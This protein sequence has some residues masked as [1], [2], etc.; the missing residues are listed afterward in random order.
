MTESSSSSDEEE[1]AKL[2]SAAWPC[3]SHRTILKG[4]NLDTELKPKKKSLRIL[5][6]FKD[7]GDYRNVDATAEQ[8]AFIAKKLTSWL[9][10]SISVVDGQTSQS[11]TSVAMVDDS[12]TYDFQLFS[13]SEPGPPVEAA[14]PERRKQR[15]L[16]SSSDSD[17]DGE[18]AK[19]SSAAV[20]YDQILQSSQL[21]APQDQQVTSN[22]SPTNNHSTLTSAK[23]SM[24]IPRNPPCDVE[25]KKRKRL[26]ESDGEKSEVQDRCR[27]DKKKKKKRK[28]RTTVGDGKNLETLNKS[29]LPEGNKTCQT[30]AQSFVKEQ[31]KDSMS[32]N[33]LPSDQSEEKRKR[34]KKKKKLGDGP[35]AHQTLHTSHS[36]M[37]SR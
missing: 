19:L 26:R 36:E 2:K 15:P 12:D 31:P 35:K 24:S 6:D 25:S 10:S 13:T 21:P 37:S 27:G 23:S 30:G 1:K 20:S 32:G 5:E 3:F 14:Q 7:Q 33:G 29:H 34:K 16:Q 17:S 8:K 18:R 4:R 22:L 28:K 11:L 9:D